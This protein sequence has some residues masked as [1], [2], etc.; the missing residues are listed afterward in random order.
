SGTGARGPGGAGARARAGAGAGQRLTPTGNAEPDAPLAR[1]AYSSTSF[2]VLTK[3]GSYVELKPAG[4][5][6]HRGHR[7][8]RDRARGG[9]TRADRLGYPQPGERRRAGTGGQGV[10]STADRPEPGVP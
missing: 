2:T 9:R 4:L 8:G 5:A 1:P 10:L 3:G 6:T 7:A